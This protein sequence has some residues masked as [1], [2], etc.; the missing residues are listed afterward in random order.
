MIL[1]IGEALMEFRRSSDD[2]LLSTPGAWAGPFPSGAPAIF[3]A[4]AA[5]LGAPV[6]LAAAVGDD[7]FGHALRARLRRDG[8]LLDALHV[9]PGRATALAFVAYDQSG[10]RD[11]WFS[12]HD[13]AAVTIDRSAVERLWPRVDWLHVSG[14]TIGFGGPVAQAVLATAEHV[15][16]TGGRISLDPNLR[17]DADAETRARMTTLARLADV[18]FPSAGELGSLGVTE[19]SLLERGA[20]ICHTHGADGATVIGGPCDVPVRVSA[21]A[22]KEIDPT[23]A[24]DTFAAAFVAA[25]RGGAEPVSATEFACR[26]AARTVEVLGAMEAPIEPS[27]MESR[28]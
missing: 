10:G 1:A 17:A 3:A 23:G 18:L 6:A 24:G 7:Q 8:V 9:A 25:T 19:Q 13:S 14:S 15:A 4:V 22:T 28:P 21:P 2:G 11:F 16:R 20:L 26:T 12:V 27:I 5:R